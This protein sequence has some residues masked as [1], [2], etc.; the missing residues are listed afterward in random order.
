MLITVLLLGLMAVA[1]SQAAKF[2]FDPWR[3]DGVAEDAPPDPTETGN[4]DVSGDIMPGDDKLFQQ[5]LPKLDTRSSSVRLNS[6]GGNV[7]A[8]L[9]IAEMIRQRG[10][11]TEVL[12]YDECYSACF[13]ILA[14]G[15]RRSIDPTARVGVHQAAIQGYAALG[16][17]LSLA[18]RLRIW[19]VPPDVTDAMLSTPP[20]GMYVLTR[21]QMLDMD[22][23]FDE[24][25]RWHLRC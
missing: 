25:T 11:S 24:C 12:P 23:G 7:L 2:E 1:P 21:G 15:Q 14:A 8:A 5:L 18:K 20:G 4:I 3:A 6:R 22:G 19:G 16:E 9:R 13:I 10:G 17:T